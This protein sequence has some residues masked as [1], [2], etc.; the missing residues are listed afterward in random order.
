MIIAIDGYSA[1]GK[2]TL[3]KDLAKHLNILY[4]DSGAVYRAIC[5]YCIDQNIHPE[6]VQSVIQ[7]LP[8]IKIE[9]QHDKN[10]KVIVNLQDVSSRLREPEV[11]RWVSEISVI[12]EVRRKVNQILRSFGAQHSLVMDGRDIGTVV[13]PKA[14][15]KFFINADK[16]IRSIRRQ[17][18][19]IEA[20]REISLDQ[21][22]EN[23]EHRDLIDSTR[24][25]SPLHQAEDAIYID[26]TNLTRETQLEYVLQFI[27]KDS[28]EWQ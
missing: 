17:K 15:Y 18:E 26:N 25:D 23:L 28:K 3:A 2:S 24:D 21:I 7:A 11:N 12:S 14:D 20:G 5:L 4:M 1:C 13:F 19:L 27:Q 10:L 9:I 6:D 8:K 22:M 16:H